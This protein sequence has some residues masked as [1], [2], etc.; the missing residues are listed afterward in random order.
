M[1]EWRWRHFL[2]HEVLSPD[3]LL[4]FEQGVLAINPILLDRAEALRSL[5]KKP[6]LINHRGLKLRGY[7]SPRENDSIP[8]AAKNS[9][10][11]KGLALDISCYSLEFDEFLGIISDSKLFSWIKPYPEHNFI[12]CDL[13]ALD[14][15]LNQR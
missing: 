9:Y 3:G 10:H 11:K 8:T 4:L 7:R 13:R 12:H 6:L 2:P 5:I 1:I 15:P 14:L